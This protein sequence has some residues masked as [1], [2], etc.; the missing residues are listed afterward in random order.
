VAEEGLFSWNC[1]EDSSVMPGLIA[2]YGATLE[3][4][5]HVYIWW[6]QI[7]TPEEGFLI[8]K[9]TSSRVCII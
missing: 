9:L 1:F 5:K 2:C 6:E 4:H 3:S 7:Q 8:K